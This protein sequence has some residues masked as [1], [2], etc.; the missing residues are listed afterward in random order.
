MKKPRIMI[1]DDE[2]SVR[3]SL[4]EWFLE[5]GF[6]VETA[7]DGLDALK[8]MDTGP[9]DLMIVDLKMPRMDGIT[10][11]RRLQE[12]DPGGTVIILTAFAAVDTAVESL[13]LGA[14]DYVT[15]PVDPDD[16]SHTVRRALE[17]KR[18]TEE[19]VRLREKVS[20][21]SSSSPIIGGSP[22]MGHVMDLVGSVAET[23]ASVVI[24]GESGTGKELIA[25]AIHAGSPR[26]F[27]PIVAV[28]CGAIPE[29]LL[30]SELFGHE[31]GAFTGA[32]YRRKGKI[33]LANG[34]TLFLDEIGEIPSKM[35]VDLLRVLESHRFTRLGGTQ[36]IES[37]FRLVCATN[38]DLEALVREE[39]FREDLYY[40]INVF[41]IDLPPLRDR[42]EDIPLL[43]EHFVDKYARS[44]GKLPKEM[45]DE[46]VELLRSY[47]WPG[48]VRELENAIER[49]MVVGKT[50]R[51]R[52][53]DLPLR[54]EQESVR[55]RDRSLE[56][57]EC[58]HIERVLREESGNVSRAARV[59]GID[60][61]TLY[62]KIKKYGIP[63]G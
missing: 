31:K 38:R 48:N 24:R 35:Q 18:L 34:G 25:R 27:F 45:T 40:R 57:L 14:F 37:D 41:S 7:E 53:E 13:K 9:F 1:V 52:P 5:D 49:A 4:R 33:E 3:S 17:Q 56:S 26:R 39:A 23:E 2:P 8:K 51:I 16:L 32:H 12:V 50:N 21:L 47:D 44:M 43:T 46:A 36:E 29:T 55:P 22:A 30:E 11:Q 42:L 63:S 59:L 58:A 54:V 61:G 6:E 62:N 20:E 19:N 15:K 60:R 10:L 28:N